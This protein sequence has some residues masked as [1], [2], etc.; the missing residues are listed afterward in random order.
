MTLYLA[1][2]PILQYPPS[3]PFPTISFSRQYLEMHSLY[4]HFLFLESVI[5]ISGI[6]ASAL[7]SIEYPRA[8]LHLLHI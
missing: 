8:L 5:S 2:T 3:H 4:P 6:S 1:P 7:L